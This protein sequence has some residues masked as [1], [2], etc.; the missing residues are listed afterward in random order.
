LQ[1]FETTEYLSFHG[2][3]PSP[4][5]IRDFYISYGKHTPPAFVTVL[6][7]SVGGKLFKAS[8]LRQAFKLS[9]PPQPLYPKAPNQ[10]PS[11]KVWRSSGTVRE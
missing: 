9:M 6:C 5:P 3:D 4:V 1:L 10:V 8:F 7:D 2:K 11:G